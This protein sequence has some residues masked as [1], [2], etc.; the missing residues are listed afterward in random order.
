MSER[1][2]EVRVHGQ[3]TVAGGK[4]H[5]DEAV[6]AACDACGETTDAV[7]SAGPDGKSP[8]LCKSCLRERLEQITLALWMFREEPKQGLPWGKIS[9]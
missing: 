9:G 8:F 4:P 7:V 6:Q 1:G 2:V 5:K 3:G